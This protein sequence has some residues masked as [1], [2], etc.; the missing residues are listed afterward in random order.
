MMR[1]A[2]LD[3]GMR[4]EEVMRYLGF[5][6]CELR[7]R[8]TR[9]HSSIR[10]GFTLLEIIIAVTILSILTAAAI[11]MVRN[12]VKRD[13]E[14]ELRLA[15]RQMRQAIDNYKQYHDRTN[16]TAIPIEWKTQSGYPKNLE[17]LVEGFIPANVV[18]TSGNRVRFLRR[19]PEDPM[20]G[21]KEWGMR[22]YKDDMDATSWG[23]E[24]VF[25][26]F[27]KSY[28]EALNGT[29]YSDW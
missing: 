14:S 19:L 9:N 18:G 25:D 8:K 7:M 28:G 22:S 16:G 3:C 27:S 29:R 11:P 17:I 1:F 15:L 10:N 23:G 12:S 20:T 2:R 5:S 24:D 4:I 21:D 26:V 6:D 13:R